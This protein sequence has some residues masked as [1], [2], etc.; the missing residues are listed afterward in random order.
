MNRQIAAAQICAPRSGNRSFSE[1][2][3]GLLGGAE[4]SR[5]TTVADQVGEPGR[6]AAVRPDDP[7]N[8]SRPGPRRGPVPGLDLRHGVDPRG[9]LHRRWTGRA[10][11]QQT[12]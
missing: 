5:W 3:F 9:R 2:H 8:R 1:R 12:T 7:A 4:M 11:S 6:D 10:S